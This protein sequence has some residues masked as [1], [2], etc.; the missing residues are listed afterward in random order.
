MVRGGSVYLTNGARRKTITA[1]TL[2]E[3]CMY[4]LSA[5][6]WMV[7][8]G[9]VFVWGC[10][11]S[12]EE[13]RALREEAARSC[14][15]SSDTL[16]CIAVSCAA[17]P[18]TSIT[19][20]TYQ[21]LRACLSRDVCVCVCVCVCVSVCVCNCTALSYGNGPCQCT[22]RHTLICTYISVQTDIHTCV[23]M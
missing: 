10:E 20:V 21:L 18:P 1:Y 7:C 5:T 16:W 13:D 15:P 19:S 2:G 12:E 14:M 4:W 8:G 9:R 22:D 11:C 3:W 6:G 17:L 23:P